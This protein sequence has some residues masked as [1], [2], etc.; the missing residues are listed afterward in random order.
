D[1]SSES[2]S[3]QLDVIRNPVY[4]C[5]N[6]PTSKLIPPSERITYTWNNIN[7][8]TITKEKH[9]RRY[10]CCGQRSTVE[11]SQRKHILK[12]VC[13]IARPGELLA[14]LGS[15]GAGKSTLLN[16]LTFRA[17]KT[18][19]L[20]GTRYVNGSPVNPKLLTCRSAYVRQDD[21]FIGNLTVREHLVF[22]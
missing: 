8:F 18:L 19:T 20:S 7:V 9:K 15:S 6:G 22:Q 11:G 21:L 12:N 5:D 10:I 3:L 2:L 14:I 13:G 4:G 1:D 16:A 17:A